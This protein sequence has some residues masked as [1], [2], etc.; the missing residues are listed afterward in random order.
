MAIE[1]CSWY[2]LW[3]YLLDEMSSIK[4]KSRVFVYNYFFI[5]I[6]KKFF[7]RRGVIMLL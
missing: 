5:H 7:L 4:S 1:A 6:E 3:V 2:E